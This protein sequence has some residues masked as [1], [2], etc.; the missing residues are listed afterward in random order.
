VAAFEELNAFVR[1]EFERKRCNPGEDLLT[2][3]LA[4]E[5]D[6]EKLSEDNILMWASV[7]LGGGNETTRALLSNS[8]DALARHPEQLASLAAYP[9][10]AAAAVEETLRWNGPVHGF[11][12]YV[13]AP[14]VV[15]GQQ[16]GEG[17]WVY[18]LY[19]SAN[20][21][22][23]VFADAERFD[24][25]ARRQKENL[26]FGVGQHYCPGNKLARLEATV[27]LEELVRRFPRWE[28]ADEGTRIK[29][30]LRSGFLN[31]PVVFHTQ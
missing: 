14:T 23:D 12:R 2:T 7:V 19:D 30:L 22:K 24:I 6:N 15:R 3:L 27:L 9:T 10:L 29:S 31:L 8:V 26:A 13:T 25:S 1:Q 11:C 28:L 21:D 4:A 20:R 16:V 5:L 17:D 18:M